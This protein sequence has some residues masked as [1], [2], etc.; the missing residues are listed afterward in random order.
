MAAFSLPGALQNLVCLSV[1]ARLWRCQHNSSQARFMPAVA[2][3]QA[4]EF[5]RLNIDES[6][7]GEA[8]W[9]HL[10]GGHSL[11]ASSF[12]S[13][14][15]DEVQATQWAQNR[16]WDET[17]TQ[18][19]LWEL[20]SAKVLLETVILRVNDL[21]THFRLPMKR[22]TSGEYLVVNFIPEAACV[23]IREVGQPKAH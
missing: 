16:W 17:C 9:E 5:L 15:D 6:G 3:L 19:Q 1:P 7:L 22:D 18:V 12:L 14:L 11:Q 20:D 4:S 2:Q 23:N 10:Q 13:V 8:V 21:R